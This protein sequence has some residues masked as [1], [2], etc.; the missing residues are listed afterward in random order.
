MPT[1]RTSARKRS[2]CSDGAA[3]A[4]AR[5]EDHEPR[6]A[7]GVRRRRSAARSARPSRGR[8][9][10]ARAGRARAASRSI[11]R[12]ACRTSTRPGRPACPSGRSRR[13]RGRRRGRRRASDRDHA[14][15]RGI[16]TSARRG[17]GGSGRRRPPRR[18]ASAGRPAG[19]SAARTAS[20][21][22]SSK[23]SSGVRYASTRRLYAV[24]PD[25]GSSTVAPPAAVA[26]PRPR[27]LLH[28]VGPLHAVGGADLGRQHALP[29]RRRPRVLRGVRRERRRSPPGWCCSRCRPASSRTRSAGASR[30]SSP[31]PCSRRR[32]CSTSR[33][34]RSDAG[35]VAFSVVSVAMGLGFTFYSG[36]MEAWLVDALA[37]DGV[38]GRA[39]LGVR[40]RPADHR[41][42]DARRDG[43]RRGA[44]PDRPVDPVRRPGRA[45]RRRLRGRVR[46]DARPRLP[47]AARDGVG[48]CPARSRATR[49]RASRTGG[50]SGRSGS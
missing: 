26:P 25:R 11:E 16:P 28:A 8:R 18:S 48:G 17:E 20:R 47:A 2:H 39:R 49:G 42:G 7:V 45:A 40:A 4:D 9:G 44:R 21:T 15:G 14:A 24:R 30:S 5:V 19:R 27:R 10:S 37:V 33:S 29:A 23:R 36:A 38:H 41:R 12:S 3:D 43:R 13:G 46:R 6:D 32:R 50:R 1:S 22:R 35:V 31:W 34:P